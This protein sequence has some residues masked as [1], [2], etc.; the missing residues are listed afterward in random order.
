MA[1][2]DRLHFVQHGG[3]ALQ[4]FMAIEGQL[5]GSDLAAGLLHLVK[6]RVS[7]LNSCVYCVGLHIRE[8]LADGETQS[9]LDHLVVWRDTDM[10]TPEERAALAWA[11]ALT[12]I[13][14]KSGLDPLHEALTRHFS[15]PEIAMLTLAIVMINSWNRLQVAAHGRRCT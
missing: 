15:D 12:A 11:E 3:E 6:L 2:H 5:A 9:R 7:Q 13:G 1:N 14:D 4:S 8:A 10:F